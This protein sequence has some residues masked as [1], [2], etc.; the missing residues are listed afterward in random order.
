MSKVKIE[1]VKVALRGHYD[2]YK[3]AVVVADYN[4]YDYYVTRRQMEAAERR[5]CIIAGDWLVMADRKGDLIV[6][7]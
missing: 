6:E 2:S 1:K 5:A 3:T 4:G 7:G